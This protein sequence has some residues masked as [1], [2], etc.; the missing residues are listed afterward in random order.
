[1]IERE[2]YVYV[3]QTSNQLVCLKSFD[4]IVEIETQLKSALEKP[5]KHK[6]KEIL[7]GL[8]QKRVLEIDLRFTS[9]YIPIVEKILAKFEKSRKNTLQVPEEYTEGISQLST[10]EQKENEQEKMT[11]S[12]TTTN[13][14]LT[15]LKSCPKYEP[16]TEFEQFSTELGLFLEIADISKTK[17]K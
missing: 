17:I 13:K 6:L 14:L 2:E 7:T 8:K 11:G 1:M 10:T 4:S 5:D 9:E 15:A 3:V 16:E 12:G